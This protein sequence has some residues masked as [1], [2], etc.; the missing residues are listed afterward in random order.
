VKFQANEIIV[1]LMLNYIAIQISEYLISGPWRDPKYTEPFTAL[2]A[3]GTRLPIIIP[4]T[5]L[6]SG[7]IIAIIAVAVLWWVFRRTVFGYQLDVLGANRKAAEYSGIRVSRLIIFTML[8]SGGLC[9]LA[10]VGEIAGIQY[11]MIENISANYGYT[12]I[13]IALL[14]KNRPLGVLVASILFAALIVGANGMEQ[15]VGVSVSIA[16]VLMG[17]V[18]L[19]VLGGEAIRSRIVNAR[20]KEESE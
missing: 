4:G 8:L 14:G 10:G 11:R 7:F 17:I 2:I 16:Q 20:L 9:G 1:T 18:L 3:S 19:F 13:A 5:R 12:A 15:S 6:H